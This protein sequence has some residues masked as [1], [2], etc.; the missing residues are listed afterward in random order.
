M[1][2]PPYLHGFATALIYRYVRNSLLPLFLHDL[3]QENVRQI[4]AFR[5]AKGHK[6]WDHCLWSACGT[7]C[8]TCASEG[9]QCRF[10]KTKNQCVILYPYFWWGFFPISH[11]R[12][13]HTALY[14]AAV[15]FKEIKKFLQYCISSLHYRISEVLQLDHNCSSVFLLFLA[16]F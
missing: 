2:A 14:S 10:E 11:F 16:L 6:C 5:M 8:A 15:N 9:R 4:L 12:L 7:R 1:R 13:W 3:K